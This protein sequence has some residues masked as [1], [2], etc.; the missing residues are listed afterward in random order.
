MKKIEKGFAATKGKN[1]IVSELP[2][3]KAIYI[4]KVVKLFGFIPIVVEKTDT[5][6]QI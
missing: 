5:A 6:V 2:K 3:F 1:K 4:V